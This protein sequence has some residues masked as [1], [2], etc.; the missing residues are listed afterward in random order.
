MSL[1]RWAA[2][3]GP[4][5]L[6]APAAVEYHPSTAAPSAPAMAPIAPVGPVLAPRPSPR[7]VAEETPAESCLRAGRRAT[8]AGD[9][10]GAVAWFDRALALEPRHS[11][12]HLCRT[13]C[14]LGLGREEEAA[15]AL[16]LAYANAPR[17]P[18]A[19][20]D[21]AR[22]CARTGLHPIALNLI[23]TALEAAP[24][25]AEPARDDSAFTT[26]RDHPQ[27]LQMTGAL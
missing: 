23:G 18:G 1:L 12:A 25:L 10:A 8:A 20:L 5:S 24:H 9:L 17:E 13:L 3:A 15:A 19:R 26:L 2:C 22:I 14:L 6:V 4:A 16:D 7:P 11:M 27:F 21:L